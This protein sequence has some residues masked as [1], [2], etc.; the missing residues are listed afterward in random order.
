MLSSEVA[1]SSP[2]KVQSGTEIHYTRQTSVA[3]RFEQESFHVRPVAPPGSSVPNGNKETPLLFQPF[4]VKDLTL[5]NRIIVSPMCM[6]SSK[7]GFMTDFH[8]AHL[9]SFAIYGAGL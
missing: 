4:T 9:G 1:T 6:Y 8:L 5:A 2:G 3:A 7:D